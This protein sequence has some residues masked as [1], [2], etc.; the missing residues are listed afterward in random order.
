MAARTAPTVETSARMR[1]VRRRD[2]TP[3]S[4]VRQ[5]LKETGVRFRVN[6]SRLPGTPDIASMTRRCAIFVHGCF[7]HGHQ[8]RLG[9]V[10]KSNRDWWLTKLADNAARDRRKVGALRALGYRVLTVWQCELDDRRGLKQRLRR[11][12]TR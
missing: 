2:T 10:P 5:L 1:R 7:W 6:V 4:S 3:E 11:F 9:T 8:C 12:W